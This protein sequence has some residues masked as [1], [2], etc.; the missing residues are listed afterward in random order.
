[1]GGQWP[2]GLR[3]DEDEL[4]VG[5]MTMKLGDD[6][7]IRGTL[8]DLELSWVVPLDHLAERVVEPEPGSVSTG[9]QVFAV[10]RH[11]ITARPMR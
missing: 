9:A 8:K 5:I 11:C 7:T 6:G 3:V 1:M 10:R 2:S 4:R